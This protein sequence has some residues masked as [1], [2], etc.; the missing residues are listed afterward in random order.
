VTVAT[1]SAYVIAV[2]AR[3]K[4]RAR[5]GPHG[6][7]LRR[8]PEGSVRVSSGLTARGAA[9]GFVL[10][11]VVTPAFAWIVGRIAGEPV[12]RPLLLGAMAG[13]IGGVLGALV[14]RHAARLLE[15]ELRAH[16]DRGRVVTLVPSERGAGDRISQD[17]ESHGALEAISLPRG[18]DLDAEAGEVIPLAFRGEVQEEEG[19]GATLVAGHEAL[20]LAATRIEDM[21]VRVAYFGRDGHAG[22]IHSST[23]GPGWIHAPVP[24]GGEGWWHD[25]AVRHGRPIRVRLAD[26]ELVLLGDARRIALLLAG[27]RNDTVS[28]AL[29]RVAERFA[30]P[31]ESARIVI[32]RIDEGGLGLALFGPREARRIAVERLSAHAI[33][34][35]EGEAAHSQERGVA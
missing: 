30:C 23:A 33:A 15:R 14:V 31:D 10:A 17:L 22:P 28:S 25:L 32:D 7:V 34:T 12:P 24:D 8:L 26:G 3:E 16:L 20:P 29:A 2:F 9:V 35:S 13:L 5:A 19:Y 4:D 11:A 18:L 21:G 27:H 1:G 6:R